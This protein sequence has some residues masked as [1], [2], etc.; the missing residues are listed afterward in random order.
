[1]DP[2]DWNIFR[3]VNAAFAEAAAA[4]A[5]QNAVVWVHDYNL[6]LV[7]K[8]LRQIRPDVRISFFHHTPFPAA[9]MFN[10]LPWRGEIIGSLLAC[11]VVGFHI[12]RY[13]NNFVSV[14]RSMFDLGTVERRA[15]RDH[16]FSEGTALAERTEPVSFN[17]DG[18][19]VRVSACPVGIDGD[20][21]RARADTYDTG[22]RVAEIRET[23][24]DCRLILSVSRTDYTK[25]N[26]EQLHTYERLLE[27]RPE[28]RG[29]V[30]L[31]LVSVEANRSMAAYEEVQNEIEQTVGRI[32][33][34]FGSFEWQPVA[35]MSKAIPFEQLVAYYRAADIAWITPLA[36][37]L[38]LVCKEFVA[39]RTD[40]DGV[41]VL[42]EFAGAAVELSSAVLTNP[43]SNRN[44]DA[45]IDQA[46]GMA[47]EERRD[48]MAAL[49]ARVQAHSI[50]TWADEQMRLF[51]P[52]EASAK[53][54]AKTSATA[55]A[56]TPK[57]TPLAPT[58]T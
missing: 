47:E 14:A 58:G 44:M 49:Q 6:W 39:A 16:L 40:G 15:V 38:N 20:F 13:V 33:G 4:E 22:S 9:D 8:Y 37:G 42:S 2:V 28:L 51:G 32:N 3:E 27:R 5:D 55:S 10:V 24:R 25:G 46:L 43:F 53:P 54:P 11:D 21:V 31:M 57:I 19:Q 56:K 23:L 17:Y 35:L 30:R 52:A 7:P 29:K 41:L 45:A 50:R 48:R 26:I 1:Y 12:P 18:R 34:R 36:D